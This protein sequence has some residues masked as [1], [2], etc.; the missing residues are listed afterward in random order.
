MRA[1]WRD[2]N[3]STGLARA[4]IGAN[5]HIC[6]YHPVEYLCF[7]LVFNFIVCCWRWWYGLPI[8]SSS[9]V[10]VRRPGPAEQFFRLTAK[11]HTCVGK[12]LFIKAILAQTQ[13]HVR[14]KQYGRLWRCCDHKPF[15]IKWIHGNMVW[16]YWLYYAC[17]YVCKL[18]KYPFKMHAHENTHAKRRMN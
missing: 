7:I 4:S 17:I 6:Y 16:S 12:C 3:K 5:G 10:Y 13:T 8:F 9:V 1:H 14:W 2:Q 11:R 18:V 15:K